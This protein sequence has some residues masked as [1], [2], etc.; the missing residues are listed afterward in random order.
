MA[1]SAYDDHANHVI[2]NSEFKAAI[3]RAAQLAQRSVSEVGAEPRR[4]QVLSRA[5]NRL[6]V[7]LVDG[8]ELPPA[9]ASARQPFADAIHEAYI[10]LPECPGRERTTFEWTGHHE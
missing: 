7:E 5:I 1:L 8:R 3:T 9:W 2:T 6:R 10:T 4:R